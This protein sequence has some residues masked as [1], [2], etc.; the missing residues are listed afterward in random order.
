MSVSVRRAAPAD[1]DAMSRV[2]TASIVELC[3][4]DHEGKPGA[5][6]AWTANKTPEGVR[7][8]L[9]NPDLVLFVAEHAGKIGAVG[10][11]RRNGEIGLNYVAPDMRF[12]GLSK[13]LL[14]RLEAELVAL[15]FAEGRP[16]LLVS[17]PDSGELRYVVL[18]GWAGD[19]VASI[20]DFLYA[21]YI[22]DGLATEAL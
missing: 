12:L 20:R 1:I 10:A 13:A 8:M 17:A 11:I 3:A 6:A 18:L 2:L 19:K 22:V 16:A 9:G 15:G 4:A 7:A 14:A 5:I 21:P